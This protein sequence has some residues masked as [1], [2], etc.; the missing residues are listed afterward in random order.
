MTQGR[1][2][3]DTEAARDPLPPPRHCPPHPVDTAA[4]DNHTRRL[5]YWQH[6]VEIWMRWKSHVRFGERS[7]IRAS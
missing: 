3:F 2:T 4:G 1:R 6:L 5:T 7:G